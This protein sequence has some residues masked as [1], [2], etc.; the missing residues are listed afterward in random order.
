VEDGQKLDRRLAI[1][2]PLFGHA[3]QGRAGPGPDR[4]ESR[5]RRCPPPRLL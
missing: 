5:A 1:A 3:G 4:P 2:R